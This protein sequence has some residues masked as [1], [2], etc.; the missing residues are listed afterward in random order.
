MQ[1]VPKP[2]P[3]QRVLALYAL[4]GLIMLGFALRLWQMQVAQAGYYRTLAENNRL[5]LITIDAPRGI[6]YDRNGTLLARNAPT[7]DV[8]IIPAYLPDEAEREM[9][10]YERLSQLLDMPVSGQTAAL[11]GAG[12]TGIKDIVEQARGVAPYRPVIIE[13]NVSREIALQV[14][15]ESPS[16]PGVNMV[17]VSSREYPLGLLTSHIV[18]Y[19]GRVSAD[20][21]QQLNDSTVSLVTGVNRDALIQFFRDVEAAKHYNPDTDRVG[22]SGVEA[23][24][25]DWLRGQKGER[26]VE[27]DV[28]G[29]EIRVIGPPIDPAPGHNMY[30]TID[31]DLQQV[32]YEALQQQIDQINTYAGALRTRR[33]AVIALDPRNGQVLTLVSL[34]TFDNNLFTRG[35]RAAAYDTLLGDDFLPLFNHAI[36]D[37][38]QPG[39]VFKIIPASAALQEGVVTR[40]TIWYDTGSIVIPNKYFPNDPRQA[41]TFYSWLRSGHGETDVVKALADSVNTFFYVTIGGLDVPDRPKYE[42]MS[43]ETFS[44]YMKAFGLGQ[45]TGIDLPGEAPGLVPNGQWKRLNYGENWALGDTYNLAIGEGFLTATPLQILNATAAVANGGTLYEPQLV[46]RIA[47]ANDRTVRSFQPQVLHSLPVSAENLAIVRQGMEAAVQWGTAVKAQVAGLN[48][49]GKTGTAEFCDDLAQKLGYCAAGIPR[50]THA[51]FTAYA[52]A[53]NPQIA[54]VVY[55]YNGG[56]GSQAAA[57]VAQQILQYWFEQQTAGGGTP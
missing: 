33:G 30:L 48:V 45:P 39:S 44:G 55:I 2:Q 7:Y 26:N 52:P 57:P 23:E 54:L 14:K 17:V 50:P 28:A 8:T 34:P 11:S 32:A 38:V 18:G 13:S 9:Q 25:E 19:T 27:E 16:L 5:R 42:G 29:R 35:I 3:N 12:Q 43:L 31:R 46:L 36:G 15:E 41:T 10:V 1:P 22:W 47:D 40:R 4:V 21:V 6:L 20:V 56:E 49:A 51:W 24:Y 53:E 37:Q